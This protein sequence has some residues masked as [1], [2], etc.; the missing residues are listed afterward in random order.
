MVILGSVMQG[1]KD[2]DDLRKLSC[3]C[4]D[5]DFESCKSAVWVLNPFKP[6][7]PKSKTTINI[8]ILPE[9]VCLWNQGIQ[10][11]E[12]C[13]GHNKT[14]SY[15]VV[16]DRCISM[17]KNLGYIEFKSNCFYRRGT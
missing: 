8:C 2:I 4:K 15:V 11:I 16:V 3:E 13:C 17:M 10:T 6:R 9:V 7:F 1:M 14:H 12:S 5:V